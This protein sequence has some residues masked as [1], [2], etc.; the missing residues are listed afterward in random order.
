MIMQIALDIDDKLDR[1]HTYPFIHM[2]EHYSYDEGER[3]E[4]NNIDDNYSSDTF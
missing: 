4:T 3:K 2:D 1:N